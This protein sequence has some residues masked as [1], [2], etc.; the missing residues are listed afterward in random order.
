[1]PLSDDEEKILAEIEAGIRKTDPNL[2]QH[3]EQSTV[4][5]HSGRRIAFSVT[6]IIVL[7][8][9]IL[10]T[11]SSSLWPV[12]FAAFGI[13][14]LVGISLVEHIVKIGKAGV[15]DAKKQAHRMNTSASW[16][17]RRSN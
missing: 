7:L 11:F 15:D 14:V 8:A 3:V 12:A 2:A 4:Y 13:M 6:G 17:G 10:F 16:K 9:V 5:R 1:M